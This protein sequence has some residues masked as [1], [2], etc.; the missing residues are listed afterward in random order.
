[1]G[2]LAEEGPGDGASGGDSASPIVH[3]VRHAHRAQGRG[4]C[5]GTRPS[6]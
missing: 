4:H 2:E 1:M 3:M 5:T 6:Q